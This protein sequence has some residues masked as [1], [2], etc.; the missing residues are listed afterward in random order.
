MR[1][2]LLGIACGF[3]L[4]I[5]VEDRVAA[6]VP[7]CAALALLLVLAR[8]GAPRRH[9]ARLDACVAFAGGAVALA[10]RLGAPA[11][12]VGAAPVTLT[13]EGAP[14]SFGTDC[15]AR[16]FVH[17]V[18]AGSALVALP[19]TA[20]DALPGDV[21]VGRLEL[22]ALRP[23]TNPGGGDPARVWARRGI[24]R[25]ARVREGALARGPT[26]AGVASWIERAR[27]AVG[28]AVDPPAGRA[29]AAPLLRALVTGERAR[30][31]PALEASFRRSGTA[32][33][34]AVS[35]LNVAWVFL[36]TQW[37]VAWLLRRAPSL[38][39]LRR[40]LPLAR[41]A[42]VALAA[43][44]AALAGLGAPVLRAAAMA[45]A[46]GVA[47]LAG[48][49]AA[50]A[51]ALSFGALVCLASDPGSLFEPGFALSFAAVAG[52]LAWRAS[53]QGIRGAIASTLGASAGTAP[54]CA[55]LGIPLPA[56][57]LLANAIAV[58]WF[59]AAVVPLAL[60]AGA[61]GALAP[62][63]APT[64]RWPGLATAELGARLVAALESDD[65]LAAA[66]APIAWALLAAGGA[67]ALRWLWLSERRGAARVMGV[68]V[69]A[70]AV[71]ALL[72]RSAAPPVPELLVLD[73]GQGD[74][75]LLRA[76]A[77]V[78]LVDAGPSQ[79]RFDAGLRVVLPALRAEGVR[80]LD[81]LAVTHADRDHI[82]GAA[83]VVD[84]VFVREVRIPGAALASHA[85]APLR[86]AAARRGVPVR[87][88]H[89]GDR[90]VAGDVALEALWPPAG[91]PSAS[92]PASL[93]LRVGVEHACAL[94]PGD[95]PAA[96]ERV[97]ARD[98]PPCRVLAL[99]HHGSR[100]SSDAAWLARLDPWVALVS[101]GRRAAPLPHPEVRARLERAGVSIWETRRFG[102][103]RVRLAAPG[104]SVS[105][106]LAS[107]LP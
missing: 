76:G 19:A 51:N 57:G 79:G 55:A 83:A 41:T 104:P 37:S 59:N 99:G 10:L 21:L 18:P 39:L 64:L 5:A 20:C 70:A 68:A 36:V 82:G 3:A 28:G 81:T 96:V 54:I 34:L 107:A 47:L 8:V 42:A 50:G 17:G 14:E 31:D 69:V 13:L 30:L 44:Y 80:A 98:A 12:V 88:I 27:R 89:A 23:Q 90:A 100:T 62:G 77:F 85:A 32:H 74:A 91:Y 45:F 105:P 4:G 87:V 106:F 61:L 7:A 40:A 94:L 66:D 73:V 63:L 78:W 25:Q 46:T 67:L 35:G 60:V 2:P 71:S 75:I 92:N 72:E 16:A 22:S 49:P 29:R 84:G 38:A 56:L 48:R 53:G 52:L 65:L 58:P 33:L 15:R 1:V 101:A 97:L 11:P 43:S 26:G 93:V 103:L 86:A 102:A 6:P 24:R 9:A 95:A